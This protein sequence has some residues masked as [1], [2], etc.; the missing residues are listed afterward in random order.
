MIWF[1]YCFWIYVHYVCILVMFK[2]CGIK[3]LKKPKKIIR[4]I[5]EKLFKCFL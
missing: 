2:F 4:K 5:L 1:L 3:K